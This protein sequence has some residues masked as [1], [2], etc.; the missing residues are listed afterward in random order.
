MYIFRFLHQTTTRL[1]KISIMMCCISFVSYIKPQRSRPAVLWLLVVYLSFPTSNH[2]SV[3]LLSFM[4]KVVYLSFPTSNHNLLQQ[5]DIL[6]VLY[7]FR[8]LHQTTTRLII[9]RML[10]RCISFVSYI[11]PQLKHDTHT[12]PNGCISFVS[13]I[14]PQLFRVVYIRFE[15]CIS[16]VSYIK[17]QLRNRAKHICKVVYLSF[18]TSNHNHGWRLD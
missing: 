7:I 6:R 12:Q 5:F 15:R 16:F 9:C 4:A 17:P 1:I 11:K 2:N 14:K 18:P 10:L 8:F 13:Y 3:P